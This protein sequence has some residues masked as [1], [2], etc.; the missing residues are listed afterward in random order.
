MKELILIVELAK[1]LGYDTEKMTF[2]EGVK[3]RSDILKAFE[4]NCE[5]H[6]KQ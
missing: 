2:D 1:A 6:K 5:T 3:L 4:K